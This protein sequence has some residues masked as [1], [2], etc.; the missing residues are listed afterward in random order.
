MASVNV[1]VKLAVELEAVVVVVV[2]DVLLEV[3]L[4]VEL[5]T[6]V[7]VVVF[8]V[9]LAVVGQGCTHLDQLT[10]CSKAWGKTSSSFKAIAHQRNASITD[11]SAV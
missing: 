6:V 2:V 10:S 1:E 9:L 4:A 3:E 8:H 5:E 11:G 7:V